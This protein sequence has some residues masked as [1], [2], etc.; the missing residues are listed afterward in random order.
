M[1]EGE[2]LLCF[3]GLGTG[4]ALWSLEP[5]AEALA[6][7]ARRAVAILAGFG[8]IARLLFFLAALVGSTRP[9]AAMSGVRTAVTGR[10]CGFRFGFSLIPRLSSLFCSEFRRGYDDFRSLSDFLAARSGAGQISER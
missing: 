7:K 1:D 8:L 6:S 2:R 5:E 9:Q 4:H 3:M 10:G